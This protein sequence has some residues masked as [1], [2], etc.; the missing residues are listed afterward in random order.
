MW[1]PIDDRSA[2]VKKNKILTVNDLKDILS[3]YNGTDPVMVTNDKMDGAYKIDAV[4][5]NRR[6][7]ND[8]DTVLINFEIVE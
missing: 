7:G 1:S 3:K 5:D 6:Y 4:Y 2:L 8:N